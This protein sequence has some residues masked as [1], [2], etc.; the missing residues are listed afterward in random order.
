[1]LVKNLA[2]ESFVALRRVYDGV[3]AAGGVLNVSIDKSMMSYV[4]S[5][6][7]AYTLALQKKKDEQSAQK[8][9]IADKRKILAEIK[10]LEEKKSKIESNRQQECLTI[11]A[12]I[13]DLTKKSAL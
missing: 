10:S 8:Q 3:Q 11:E 1:M 4:K 2:E 9:K 13:K 7:S 5:S 12:K 6:H